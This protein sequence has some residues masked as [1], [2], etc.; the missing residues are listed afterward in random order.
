MHDPAATKP[1]LHRK[2]LEKQGVFYLEPQLFSYSDRISAKDVD[3]SSEKVFDSIREYLSYGP[4]GFS[5]L[6]GYG[7]QIPA[8]VDWLRELL[9]DSKLV[10]PTYAKDAL[11]PKERQDLPPHIYFEDEAQVLL[12]SAE[13]EE[14]KNKFKRMF[15]TCREIAKLA[16]CHQENCETEAEWQYF[17]KRYIFEPYCEREGMPENKYVIAC[18]IFIPLTLICQ[19]LQGPFV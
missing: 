3:E 12:T 14:Q 9:L 6:G 5:L 16:L 1:K 13:Q 19:F 18:S 8:H 4:R 11:L 2:N 10:I 15:G 17:M 7:W